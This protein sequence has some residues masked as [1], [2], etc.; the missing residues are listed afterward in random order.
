[1]KRLVVVGRKHQHLRARGISPELLDCLQFI[2]HRHGHVEQRDVGLE[3]L[4]EID[5]LAPVLGLAYYLDFVRSIEDQTKPLPYH[6][7]VLRQQNADSFYFHTSVGLNSSRG[8]Q[9]KPRFTAAATSN[10]CEMTRAR[11]Y[12]GNRDL[13]AVRASYTILA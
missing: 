2:E 10:C 12:Q 11:C 4:G 9:Y 13:S 8:I 5:C 3:I 6:G 7:M 1:M